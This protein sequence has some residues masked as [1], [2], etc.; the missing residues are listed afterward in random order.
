MREAYPDRLHKPYYPNGGLYSP[1]PGCRDRRTGSAAMRPSRRAPGYGNQRVG[2][3]RNG[4]GRRSGDRDLH[5]PKALR[6]RI[7]SHC[8]GAEPDMCGLLAKAIDA[9]LPPA[10]DVTAR[11]FAHPYLRQAEAR[12]EREHD[13][14]AG[15]EIQAAILRGELDKAGAQ[16]RELIDGWPQWKRDLAERVLRPSTPA[17]GRWG[18]WMSRTTGPR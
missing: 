14:H 18:S 5:C 9:H 11:P 4:W 1:G 8:A 2:L 6:E 13:R 16:A 17:L 3:R 7:R 10:K 12:A 15:R